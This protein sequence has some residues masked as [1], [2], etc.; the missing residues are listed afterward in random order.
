MNLAHLSI[1]IERL[2][3]AAIGE[4]VWMTGKR[5]YEYQD[6]SAKVVAVLKLVRAAHGINA[7]DLLC[8]AGFFIDFGII[9][10]CV[11]D[12]VTEVYFLLEDYPKTSGNVDRFVAS[13]L[14]TVLMDTCRPTR[15]KFS[16]IKSGMREFVF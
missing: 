5:V 4:P 13:F 12:C 1:L 10:R 8:H 14:K 15:P 11:G 2:R 3:K 6:H 16:Q 9:I 7:L